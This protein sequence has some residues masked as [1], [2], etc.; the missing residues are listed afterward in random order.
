MILVFAGLET[1]SMALHSDEP[2][3]RKAE[4]GLPSHAL[5]K[6]LRNHVVCQIT[7]SVDLQST[8]HRNINVTTSDHAE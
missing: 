1:K 4:Y 5:H 6:F 3:Y 8:E 7:R 2:G